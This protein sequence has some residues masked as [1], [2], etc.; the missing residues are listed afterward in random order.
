MSK[1]KSER[2]V[3]LLIMMLSAR[4]YV[5]K[6]QIRSTIEGY[7]HQSDGAFERMFE[8]DKEELRAAGVP[9]ATGS[10]EPDLDIEAG[11]RIER[12][13]F[14]LPP[15]AFTPEELAVLGAAASVW[16]DSVAAQQTVDALETL[17]AAGADPDPERLMTLR[18]R[19]PAE[20]GFDAAR[21]ALLARREVRFDYR[22]Q[23]RQVQPWRLS[24]RRGRWYLL[25]FD[26]QRSAPRNFKLSRVTSDVAAVGPT[27]AY[28]VPPAD[29]LAGLVR[30]DGDR[31]GAFAVV[32]LRDQ[33]GGDVRR[34]A[35]PATWDHPLPEGFTAWRLESPRPEILAADICELGPDAICLA[36]Q[37]LRDMVIR[38]LQGI[39][40]RWEA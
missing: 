3:N 39:A 6:H 10:N 17:R 30:F 2:L 15:V 26:L 38:Q 37:E 32:A 11:Y 7:R 16:Q 29:E 34:M 8:R 21:E 9:I 28:E 33:M 35:Q 4:G 24:Q 14:E 27:H 18:P 12:S 20:P 13:D 5:T 36:P 1:A 22:G 19:I 25:G 40:D 31:D 23:P